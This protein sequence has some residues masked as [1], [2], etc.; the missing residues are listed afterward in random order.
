MIPRAWFALV[1]LCLAQNGMAKTVC[2][3]DA[4]GSTI[5]D[6]GLPAACQGRAYRELNSQGAVSR[7][8]DAPLTPAQQAK[9]DQEIAKRKEE[10]KH[11]LEREKQDRLLLATY[12][13]VEDIDLTRDRI[14]GDQTKSL[15]QIA[16]KLD[17]LQ[18]Q[19]THLANELE[20]YKKHEVPAALRQQIEIN[21]KQTQA[22]QILRDNKEKEIE[23]LRKHFDEDKQ[24]Y[25]DI[26]GRR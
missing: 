24:R 11:R 16:A 20:F 7:S 14:L 23:A 21:A 3:T 17:D 9:H 4:K 5:C 15:A 10:E 6:D 13:S 18:K 8:V 12:S 26:S 25:L 2:C 19:K 1:V 22:Q